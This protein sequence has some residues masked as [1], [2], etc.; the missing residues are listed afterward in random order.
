ME[1]KSVLRASC[2]ISGMPATDSR[3]LSAERR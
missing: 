3:V 1:M 2:D